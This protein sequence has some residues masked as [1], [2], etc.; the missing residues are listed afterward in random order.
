MNFDEVRYSK[1][2][3][4][5]F[6]RAQSP[7]LTSCVL[8]MCR[9]GKTNTA[10]LRLN[11]AILL[12]LILCRRPIPRPQDNF[13]VNGRKLLDGIVVG[14]AFRQRE[15]RRQRRTQMRGGEHERE[16]FVPTRTKVSWQQILFPQH[17]RGNVLGER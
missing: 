9:A 15:V 14:K 10:R 6:M 5:I 7:T 1:A 13:E 3:V 17:N 8:L 4:K 12:D 2:L 11:T 16:I